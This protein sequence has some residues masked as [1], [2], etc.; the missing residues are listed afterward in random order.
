VLILTELR[1]AVQ[2]FYLIAYLVEYTPVDKVVNRVKAGKTKPKEEVI[3]SSV[4]RSRSPLQSVESD[5]PTRARR[6]DSSSSARSHRHQLGRGRR[7][8]RARRLAA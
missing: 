7:R 8:E 3:Q 5:S 2:V 4:S 6:A 1:I